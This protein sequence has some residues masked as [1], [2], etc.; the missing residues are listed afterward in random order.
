MSCTWCRSNVSGRSGS[1]L[2]LCAAVLIDQRTLVES[3]ACFAKWVASRQDQYE[4]T[5]NRN[6]STCRFSVVFRL[7][8]LETELWRKHIHQHVAVSSPY[9]I[10]K[11]CHILHRL[12]MPIRWKAA[13]GSSQPP[14]CSS[15][16]TSDPKG[17]E[18]WAQEICH[19][20]RDL[21]E[22]QET[23]SLDPRKMQ[24]KT[25]LSKPFKTMSRYI[26]TSKKH[27]Q[28]N[29]LVTEIT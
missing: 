21:N 24:P 1:L 5:T 15:I 16:S 11:A 17:W 20:L 12:S 22:L 7:W 25:S 6:P 4:L 18:V 8:N 19:V 26:F 13:K 29:I 14:R 27:I 28:G 10:H 9:W 23:W 2:D 3:Y